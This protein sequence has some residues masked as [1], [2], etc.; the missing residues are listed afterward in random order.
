MDTIS[1]VWLWFAAAAMALVLAAAVAAYYFLRPQRKAENEVEEHRTDEW[2]ATGRI[3]LTDPQSLGNFVLQAEETRV[4]ESAG[5]VE[6]RQIRWRRAT[7]DEARKVVKEYHAQRNLTMKAN[8]IVTSTEG[9]ERGSV[10]EIEHEDPR[11]EKNKAVE[12]ESTA[13]DETTV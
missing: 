11:G 8:F 2:I 7:L 3:D 4:L 10:V 5:G 12:K 13:S 9:S 6:H 1:N